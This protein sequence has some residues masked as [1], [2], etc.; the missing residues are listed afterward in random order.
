MLFPVAA[1][2]DVVAAFDW[3]PLVLV[4]GALTIV[5]ATA[6]AALLCDP[7]VA[8]E[9]DMLPLLLVLLCAKA[10]DAAATAMTTRIGPYA[11]PC[12]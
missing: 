12:G 5:P 3:L 10:G 4:I 8:V 2:R 6:P 11:K 1:D 7:D 9:P